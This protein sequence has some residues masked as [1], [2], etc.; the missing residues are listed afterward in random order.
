METSKQDTALPNTTLD[1]HE[2]VEVTAGATEEKLG[3]DYD[4]RVMVRMG[5]KQELRREFQF[6]S[7]WGYAVILGATWEFALI[8][9]V[10]S[11]PNGGTA[12]TVYMF[13]VA[14]VGMF[15]TMLCEL[16]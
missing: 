11:L 7:I 1:V 12:G 3:N 4:Q 2:L 9:G 13:L 16:I 6:F 14:C 10:L 5:K 15:F 8:D